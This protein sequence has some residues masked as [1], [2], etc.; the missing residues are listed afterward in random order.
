MIQISECCRSLPC[1]QHEHPLLSS[2]E[3]KKDMAFEIQ[4]IKNKNLWVVLFV[5]SCLPIVFIHAQVWHAFCNKSCANFGL[6]FSKPLHFFFPCPSLSKRRKC[7]SHF[8]NTSSNISFH[9]ST[10]GETFQSLMGD[11]KKK[12]ELLSKHE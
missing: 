11:S 3:E 12:S 7:F 1:K 4:K 2:F 6:N 9:H 8:G 5:R 10:L